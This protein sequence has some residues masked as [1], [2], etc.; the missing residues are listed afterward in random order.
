MRIQKH[1]I[2]FTVQKAPGNIEEEEIIV[3][4]QKE[5]DDHYDKII[6]K[7]GRKVI[8]VHKFKTKV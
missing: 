6:S 5:I 1:R 8:G 3:S 7:K 2:V 4:T